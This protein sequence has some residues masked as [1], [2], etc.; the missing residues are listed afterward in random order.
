MSIKVGIPD[1]CQQRLKDSDTVQL[2]LPDLHQSTAYFPNAIIFGHPQCGTFCPT[3]VS[4]LSL[5]YQLDIFTRWGQLVYHLHPIRL[6]E[7]HQPLWP[8]PPSGHL[9]LPCPCLHADGTVRN[10]HGTVLLIK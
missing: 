9:C 7:R 6:L 3:Y 8:A 4:A 5:D 10:Y 2:L 1:L